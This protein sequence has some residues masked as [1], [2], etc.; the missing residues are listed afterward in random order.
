MHVSVVPLLL[1]ASS[2]ACGAVTPTGTARTLTNQYGG[3]GIPQ[4]EAID[5][6]TAP[7]CAATTAVAV[8]GSRPLDED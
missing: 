4:V 8:G 6:I 3:Q 1:C 7:A 2:D 5:L